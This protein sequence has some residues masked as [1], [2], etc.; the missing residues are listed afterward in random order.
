MKTRVIISAILLTFPVVIAAQRYVPDDDIYY[1]PKDKKE[2]P[3]KK[4]QEDISREA[5]L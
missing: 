1:S 5:V 2:I 4:K 3:E